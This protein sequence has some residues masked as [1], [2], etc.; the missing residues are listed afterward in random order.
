MTAKLLI[1]IPPNW[2]YTLILAPGQVYTAGRASVNHIHL[3]ALGVAGNHAEF[4]SCETRWMVRD[5][6]TQTGTVVNGQRVKE[7]RLSDGDVVKLGAAEMVYQCPADR[8]QEEER[9]RTRGLVA[10]R[11]HEIREA[12]NRNKSDSVVL[13][14]RDFSSPGM[15]PAAPAPIGAPGAPP[16]LA[17]DDLV[18]IAQQLAAILSEVLNHPGSTDE[19]FAFMLK[20]LRESVGADNGFLMLVDPVRH[21]W[22]IRAWVG[23]GHLWTDYEK[24]HPVPLTIANQCYQKGKLLSNA[25]EFDTGEDEPIESKSMAIMQVH[26]YIAVPLLEGRERRGVLYFDNR[27]TI[28]MFSARELKLIERAGNYILEIERQKV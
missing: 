15:T 1:D 16:P 9:D 12:I 4:V 17:G 22:V 10:E 18:W 27:R 28:K 21:R 19:A 24:E 13:D 3:P 14:P 25:V 23:E 7:A 6:N 8:K 5:L 20:R 2:A 11:E 26:C